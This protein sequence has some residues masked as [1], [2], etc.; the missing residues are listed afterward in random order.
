MK[1]VVNKNGNKIMKVWTYIKNLF[2]K[3]GEET[4][5]WS[6]GQIMFKYNY[7]N[8]EYHGEQIVYDLNGQID[9]KKYY[10]NDKLV[11]QEEWIAYDRK[12][13]IEMM[14]NL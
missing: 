13:K 14:S 4:G 3:Q 5:Y 1:K 11:S 10:I 9:Y 12:L 6:N 7:R 8:G 2:L